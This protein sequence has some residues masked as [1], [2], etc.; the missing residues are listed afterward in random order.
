MAPRLEAVPRIDRRRDRKRIG[1]HRADAVLPDGRIIEL[2]ADYL[3]AD[4][5]AEHERYYGPRLRWI[6]RCHWLHRLH[7][8]RHGFWWK[9]GAKS[10][11]RHHRPVW[12]HVENEL[13][14]VELG[15]VSRYDGSGFCIGER[16][17]GR[18]LRYRPAPRSIRCRSVEEGRRDRDTRPTQSADKENPMTTER[19]DNVTA[20]PTRTPPTLTWEEQVAM[21]EVCRNQPAFRLLDPVEAAVLVWDTYEAMIGAL[22]NDLPDDVE[23][24]IHVASIVIENVADHLRDGHVRLHYDGRSP[25]LAVDLEDETRSNP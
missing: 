25:Y 5:I 4:E 16:V 1:D 21:G 9:H 7:F 11:A 14:Q 13:W 10:M 20:L 6:Y 8:G 15:V 17:V 23:R 18:I 22:P 24:K 3:S 19:P 2:Q 12:W